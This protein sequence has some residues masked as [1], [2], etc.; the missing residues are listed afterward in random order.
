MNDSQR[1]IGS[2]ADY[3]ALEM[4]PEPNFD[5]IPNVS[6]VFSSNAH[7]LASSVYEA[8]WLCTLSFPVIAET[9]TCLAH[10][11]SRRAAD[12]TLSHLTISPVVRLR[13]VIGRFMDRVLRLCFI[14]IP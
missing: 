7:G 9:L 12:A 8:M 1:R 11:F 2:Y 14:L 10:A 4:R 6:N 13:R 5:V 3:N